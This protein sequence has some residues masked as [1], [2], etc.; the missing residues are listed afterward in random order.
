MVQVVGRVY[1]LLPLVYSRSS[2][3]GLVHRVQSQSLGVLDLVE[4]LPFR[5]T[6]A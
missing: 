4:G 6:T 5:S 2:S 1:I 3:V